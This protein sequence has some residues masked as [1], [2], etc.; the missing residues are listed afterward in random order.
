[1]PTETN[2]WWKWKWLRGLEGEMYVHAEPSATQAAYDQAERRYLEIVRDLEVNLREGNTEGQA[3]CLEALGEAS[4]AMREADR[5][6]GGAVERAVTEQDI[7]FP[8][9]EYR[10]PRF[11]MEGDRLVSLPAM[12]E[13]YTPEQ[14]A[15]Y[16]R[17]VLGR[18]LPTSHH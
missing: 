17:R 8:S 18:V 12:A 14:W 16:R 13:E 4:A 5:L 2:D 3:R 7:P 11:A 15:E 10:E 9:T 1:M 6:N